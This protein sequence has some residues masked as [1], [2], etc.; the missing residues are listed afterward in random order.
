MFGVPGAVC[1]IQATTNL[2]PPVWLEV[3]RLLESGSTVT[4]GGLA[5]TASRQFYWV[6]QVGP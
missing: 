5:A 4:V 2:V 6:E 1:S 3:E